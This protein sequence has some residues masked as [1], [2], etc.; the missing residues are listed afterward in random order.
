MIPV[1]Y[2]RKTQPGIGLEKDFAFKSLNVQKSSARKLTALQ[3]KCL[4]STYASRFA[5]MILMNKMNNNCAFLYDLQV[6]LAA[7]KHHFDADWNLQFSII[8]IEL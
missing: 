1:M 3:I 4:I 5:H 8:I 2:K 6:L 7:E